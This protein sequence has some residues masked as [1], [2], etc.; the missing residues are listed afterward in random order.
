MLTS[1]D[2]QTLAD[3]IFKFTLVHRNIEIDIGQLLSIA[4]CFPR[5]SID[6][7]T[8]VHGQ[9]F[10]YGL[11]DLFIAFNDNAFALFQL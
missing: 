3:R 10:L 4:G 9:H 11:R 8:V 2:P 5:E 1:A 7:K 6:V